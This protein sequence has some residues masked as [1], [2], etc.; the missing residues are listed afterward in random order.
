MSPLRPMPLDFNPVRP[1]D[2]LGDL[3]SKFVRLDVSLLSKIG[4]DTANVDLRV[5]ATTFNLYRKCAV[6]QVR[7]CSPSHAEV[8]SVPAT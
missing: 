8:R 7:G 4:M 6:V 3:N 1:L 2:K 5:D